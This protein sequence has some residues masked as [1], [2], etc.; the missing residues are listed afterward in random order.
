[1]WVKMHRCLLKKPIWQ[2]QNLFRVFSWCLLKASWNHHEQIV[3]MTKVQLEPGQFV[4]GRLKASEETG[5]HES[6]IRNCINWLKQNNT[7]TIKSTNKYSVITIINWALYQSGE[8][9]QDSQQDS[10]QDNNRTTTGQQQDTTKNTK[11]IK[12]VKEETYDYFSDFWAE[13]PKHRKGVKADVLRYWKT[14]KMNDELM[15]KIMKK[16][17][18]EIESVSWTKDEGQYVPK[19]IK[20]LKE[21][22]WEDGK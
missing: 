10:Q 16:L 9:E 3:G 2:N 17:F 8:D 20:W 19:A 1:M 12:K 18:S 21:A 4:Y 5:L 15:E 22:R 6:T 13:Y 11:K 14:L 7:L